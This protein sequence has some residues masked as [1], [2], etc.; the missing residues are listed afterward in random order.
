M[1]DL[2]A[3]YRAVRPAD[4]DAVRPEAPQ[5]GTRPAWGTLGAAIDHRIRH[6][7]SDQR[8]PSESV[9]K[10]VAGAAARPS[11]PVRQAVTQT[12]E[13]LCAAL[14]DLI[15]HERPYDRAQP[16]ALASASEE[17]LN[18]LC[19]VMAWFEEVYRSGRSF[20]GRRSARPTLT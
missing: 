20:R 2:S 14:A 4:A 3:D 5:D 12:G 19:Y 18:R 11:R 17:E 9:R 6:A 15:E 1:A 8:T 10:G 13:A 7:F 16:I